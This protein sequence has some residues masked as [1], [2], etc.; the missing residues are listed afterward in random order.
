[1]IAAIV[2]EQAASDEALHALFPA[3]ATAFKPE[4]LVDVGSGLSWASAHRAGGTGAGSV[5]GFRDPQSGRTAVV[6]G[7][8]FNL[9]DLAPDLVGSEDA[10]ARAVL[11]LF[12]SGDPEWPLRLR[13]QFAIVIWDPATRTTTALRDRFGIMSLYF[14]PTK[15]GVAFAS[16]AKQLLSLDG[17]K[18]EPDREM[19]AAYLVD[20]ILRNTAFSTERTF[21]AAHFYVH[22]GGVGFGKKIN[23]QAT[24][25]K[26]A[27]GHQECNEHYR[28][29][30]VLYASFCKLHGSIGSW[31]QRM[32]RWISMPGLLP[33][34]GSHLS[35]LANDGTL[36]Q[37]TRNGH[38]YAVAQI[39]SFGYF[40][41]AT[42]FV[43]GLAR[44]TDLAFCDVIAVQQ[45]N[46][47]NAVA[48]IHG[49]LGKKD[50]FVLFLAGN[51]GL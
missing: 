4:I 11:N 5:S 30:G 18:S 26:H 46:F 47:I 36:V 8:I 31:L 6:Y 21:F 20:D 51:G 44:G 22:S 39:Q 48:I 25:G 33:C 17:A 49:A 28:E 32:A 12:A 14:R 10:A 50:G 9:R 34:W 1:M 35:L 38:G 42:M 29:D 45:K 23:G 37:F 40:K 41:T 3:G 43:L 27:E 13:G 2:T 24:V 19:V 16:A 15:N 7:H